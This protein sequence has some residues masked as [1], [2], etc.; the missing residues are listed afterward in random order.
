MVRHAQAT[1]VT[2][3]L[4]RTDEKVTL[5]LHDNGRGIRAEDLSNPRALGLLGMHERAS[6]MGGRFRLRGEPGAG[7]TATLTIPAEFAAQKP[8]QL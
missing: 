5:E 2:V 8:S 6:L 3:V 1:R 7:T 4:S